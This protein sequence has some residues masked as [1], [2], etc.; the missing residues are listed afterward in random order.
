MLA[1]QKTSKSD[2]NTQKSFYNAANIIMMLAMIFGYHVARENNLI[3]SHISFTAT[4]L[5]AIFYG[6]EYRFNKNNVYYWAFWILT[7]AA[8]FIESYVLTSHELY[9]SYA[10][11]VLAMLPTILARLKL[12]SELETRLPSTSLIFSVIAVFVIIGLKIESQSTTADLII[13]TAASSYLA[14]ANY[15][16]TKKPFFYAG[17]NICW[18]YL[19]IPSLNSLM[20]SWQRY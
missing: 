15:Y 12:F 2:T 20:L 17:F 8:V 3:Y 7:G 18:L 4:T 19:R 6:L 13:I 1:F 9:Q 14:Y 5:G 11:L 16:F 10:L